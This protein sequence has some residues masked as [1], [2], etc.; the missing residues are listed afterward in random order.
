[1]AECFRVAAGP[2]SWSRCPVAGRSG[3]ARAGPAPAAPRLLLLRSTGVLGGGVGVSA[4]RPRAET[5]SGASR[6]EERPTRRGSAGPGSGAPRGGGGDGRGRLLGAR[7]PSLA[8]DPHGPGGGLAG[9][10]NGRG[11]PGAA[12][13]E[14]PLSATRSAGHPAPR[15]LPRRGPRSPAAGPGLYWRCDLGQVTWSSEPQLP[16][17]LHGVNLPASASVGVGGY[18]CEARPRA[19]S[20]RPVNDRCGE[21]IH[22]PVG[23]ARVWDEAVFRN[24][25]GA[26]RQEE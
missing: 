23:R 15:R 4:R 22:K 14:H 8:R 20:R 6:A 10:G 13:E 9:F 2:G 24:C 3:R 19:Y 18:A 1:M 12:Q 7:R 25:G 26:P 17:E 11:R 21:F 5:A 16:D